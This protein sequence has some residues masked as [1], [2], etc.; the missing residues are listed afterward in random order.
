MLAQWYCRSAL[1]HLL[2]ALGVGLYAG[3]AQ[4]LRVLPA[5]ATLAS[6][7]WVGMSVAGLMARRHPGLAQRRPAWWQF[8]LAQAAVLLLAIGQL[9]AIAEPVPGTVV[10]LAALVALVL[11][12]VVAMGL[13]LAVLLWRRSARATPAQPTAV[14]NPA[15]DLVAAASV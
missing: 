4:D 1:L 5:I 7:G 6:L 9:V 8:G 10:V 13:G 15:P 12:V 3:L 11:A 14:T 2:V